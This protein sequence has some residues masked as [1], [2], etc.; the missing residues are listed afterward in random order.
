[1]KSLHIAAI[2]TLLVFVSS[3]TTTT[4]TRRH[5]TLTEQLEYIDSVVV[6]PPRVEIEYVTLTGE[7]ERLTEQEDTIRIQLI[8]MAEHR[9]TSRGY[10]VVE[11][12]FEGA[13]KSNEEF[14]YTVTQVREEFD[15]AKK[16]LQLGKGLTIEEATTLKASIGEVVNV[17]AEETGAD[18]ILLMRYEGFEKSKGYKSKDIGTSILVGILTGIVPVAAPTG[19]ITEVALID[20]ATGDVLWAD[21]MGGVLGTSVAATAMSTLPIDVDPTEDVSLVEVKE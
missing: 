3:C 14:A 13:I 20:G 10:H 19:A 11:F 5:P 15:Q 9:L 1:M 16:E 8:Q 12:D 4:S 2:I 7:N 21:I 17:V 18:A 6:I